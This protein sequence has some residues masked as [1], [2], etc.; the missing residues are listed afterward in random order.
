MSEGY[1]HIMLRILLHLLV[2][3]S[4]T[5]SA[6][7]AAPLGPGSLP[8]FV[9]PGESALRL[10]M[11]VPVVNQVV[12]VP[13]VDTLLDE[14]A[15]WTPQG[16]WPV[17][18]EE[19]FLAS[20]FIR[21]FQPARV[22]RRTARGEDSGTAATRQHLMQSTVAG[23]W[24]GQAGAPVRSLVTKTG[25]LPPPGL[26]ITEASDPSAAAAVLLAA[27]RGQPIAFLDMV[28]GDPN[29]VLGTDKTMALAA[30]VEQAAVRTGL[31]WEGLGDQIDTV[32]LCRRL[33]ARVTTR[34]PVANPAAQGEPVALTDVIGRRA[35]GSRWAF[36][37][38]LVGSSALTTYQANCSLFL[39]RDSAWMGNTY[40]DTGSWATWGLGAA[41]EVLT[42]AGYAVSL[43]EHV[44]LNQLL[45][46]TR[47]GLD[48]SQIWMNSKGNADFFRM[49]DQADADPGEVPI[50]NQPAALNFVHSWSLR[51]PDDLH[52]VGG[53]WLGR[54]VYCYT[55]SSQEPQLNGFVQPSLMARRLAGGVPWI[56]ASRYWDESKAAMARVW[57]INTIGDPLMIAPP[58]PQTA[59]RR[60]PPTKEALPLGSIDVRAAAV[61]RM[62][63]LESLTSDEAFAA[64][65]HDV[66]L[67]GQDEIAAQLW[68]AAVQRQAAGSASARAVFG[69]LFRLAK[70]ADMLEAWKRLVPATPLEADM[71]WASFAAQATMGQLSP[72]EVEALRQ[73]IGPGAVVHRTKVLAPVI[74]RHWGRSAAMA[75]ISAAR[76]HATS[77]RQRQELDAV[78]KEF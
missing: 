7:E 40:P 29:T 32:T 60:R 27:G 39:H 55:G 66:V 14:V 28:A 73:A 48:E 3:V 68:A 9:R 21:A 51:S 36:T 37:G 50:L 52:S 43:H 64:A 26:V 54:G 58:P 35:D 45:A 24:G 25:L 44:S 72:E 77:P 47:T 65:I 23:V 30:A 69:A 67:I 10:R 18:I 61:A 16:H 2:L 8:W 15:K 71:L 12:L 4:T 31:E 78:S 56:I 17:L 49:G 20:M 41:A 59:R 6:Q 22:I 70:Q 46:L 76:A 13:D 74:A 1:A 34:M 62:K 75:A 57:R 63:S 19:P 42:Q 11:Q 38:W 5:A 33:P 53:R